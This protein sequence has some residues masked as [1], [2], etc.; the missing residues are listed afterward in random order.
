MEQLNT[1][2]NQPDELLPKKLKRFETKYI[3]LAVVLFALAVGTSFYLGRITKISD[4][5]VIENSILPTVSPTNS[6]VNEPSLNENIINNTK[7]YPL[8][9]DC[10]TNGCLFKDDENEATFG[11][12]PLEGYFTTYD[13]KD[14]GDVDVKC[15]AIV[16]TGGNDELIKNLKD[17]V[18]RGNSINSINEKGEI[19]LNIDLQA[20][21][22][23][24]KDKITSS[25]ESKPAHFDVIRML[26]EQRGAAS[27]CT[28]FIY[29]VAVK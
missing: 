25:S 15:D 16:V 9:G 8:I 19:V 2:I 12:A 11:F 14:W 5:A 24:Y 10:N 20:I 1:P 17:W 22:E 21:D 27:S 6:T 28:S 3:V 18:E 13:K 4:K 29:I 26:P 7:T 23:E